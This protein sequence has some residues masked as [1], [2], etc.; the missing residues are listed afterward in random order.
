M[1]N[2]VLATLVVLILLLGGGF[3]Y[4]RSTLKQ[5]APSPIV[6]TGSPTAPPIIRK[7]G[8]ILIKLD[9]V[10]GSPVPQGG[11]ATLAEENGKVV[12][13]VSITQNKLAGPQ[14][15]HI[16]SGSCVKP[17]EVLYPLTNVVDGKSETTLNVTMKDLQAKGALLI[18]VHKSAAEI[19][20]Y[21]AC[22]ELP[23]SGTMMQEGTSEATP[24]PT[25]ATGNP[26]GY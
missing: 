18:N 1:K 9:P 20:V 10:Q 8:E 26:T 2:S 21:T 7:E 11:Y 25:K 23:S 13:K 16:H 15:V 17:G 24:S 3:L 22:G 19:S 6:V 12:V 14:P 5:P 4:Y